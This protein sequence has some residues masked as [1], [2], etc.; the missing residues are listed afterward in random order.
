MT[1]PH[2][3]VARERQM[4]QRAQALYDMARTLTDGPTEEEL[5]RRVVHT[6]VDVLGVN[7]AVL[8]ILSE[9]LPHVD[10]FI[11]A[12]PGAVHVQRPAWQE[13][14]TGLTGWVLRERRVARSPMGQDDPREGPEARQRRRE[15]MCGDIVV[16]P[17]MMKARVFGTL[18]LINLPWG[19]S[20]TDDDVAWLEALVHQ[21]AA[22]IQQERLIQQLQRHALFDARTGL[23]ARPLANDRLRQ[24]LWHARRS[25]TSFALLLLQPDL[26]T[27]VHRAS[28]AEFRDALAVQVT[29]RLQDLPATVSTLAHWDD[30]TLMLIAEDVPDEHHAFRVVNQVMNA[31]AEPFTVPG[32]LAP[33]HV[34]ASVGVSMFPTDG[35]DVVAL[36]KHA[37]LAL[38]NAKHAGGGSGA[39]FSPTVT[40][41]QRI[42][43]QIA[44]ALPGALERNELFLVYQP[45]L[46]AQRRLWGFEALLRWRH[47]TLGLVP[48]DVF[49]PVAERNGLILPLGEWVTRQACQQLHAWQS[50]GYENLHMAVN[51]SQLQ[52]QQEDFIDQVEAALTASSLD[53]AQLELE[54]TEQMVFQCSEAVRT[55]LAALRDLGVRLA[56]DDF[57][58]GHS[59]MQTLTQ[60]S[61]DVLKLDQSFVRDL[62][63]NARTQRIVKSIID[64][65]HD[66]DMTVVAEGV[67]SAVQWQLTQALECDRTQGY[68][69]SRPLAAEA[70]PA[71]MILHSSNA[72]GLPY[73]ES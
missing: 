46:D 34:T 50:S 64:L 72:R 42:A 27:D 41:Q 71:W 58:V 32:T 8:L 3:V 63:G 2:R 47:G 69:L 5:L 22:A 38:Y 28:S 23:P 54:L 33:L 9:D 60:V 48:P 14:A 51:V 53:G 39:R 36:Q 7:R 45:Q 24:S 1:E 40:D 13:L 11:V 29:R 30:E 20:F 73:S 62:E 35:Q 49:I 56:L 55:K 18:T 25:A 17:I 26:P 57:G 10:H 70:I 4:L 19:P 66:M 6:A 68:L 16:L 12:G 52:L 59:S 31:F 65:A 37:A 21:A 67:E 15:T 43:Q 44:A 61:F